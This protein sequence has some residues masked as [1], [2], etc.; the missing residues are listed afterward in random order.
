MSSRSELALK[1]SSLEAISNPRGRSAVVRFAGGIPGHVVRGSPWSAPL[2]RRLV[3][4]IGHA[5]SS[6]LGAPEP[7]GTRHLSGVPELPRIS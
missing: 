2:W 7:P 3:P 4:A 5:P 1:S 6:Q